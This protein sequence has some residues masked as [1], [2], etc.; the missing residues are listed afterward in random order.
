MGRK[1]DTARGISTGGAL[2]GGFFVFAFAAL[3]AFVAVLAF[4]GFAHAAAYEYSNVRIDAQ[5][6]T[7]ADFRVVEHRVL[8]FSGRST[9]YSQQ[10]SYVANNQLMVVNTVRI[11]PIDDEGNVAGEWTTM[12]PTAFKTAWRDGVS[13]D[14]LSELTGKNAY[15][16]DK[17][18]NTIHLYFPA[19]AGDSIV[20]ELD[21]SIANGA[22][23]YKDI[24][25]VCMK[26]VNESNVAD[27]HNVVFTVSLPVP[28]GAT[29]APGENVYAW[30]HGPSD[31][32]VD[33]QGAVVTFTDDL[34]RAGQYAEAHVV[35]PS[36]WL[37]NISGSSARIYKD[38]THLPWVLKA[39]AKWQDSYRYSAM[40]D[41]RFSL[42]VGAICLLIM[43][44]GL[45]L[46]HKFGKAHSLADAPVEQLSAQA[47]RDF[48][49]G[50]HPAMALRLM[51]GR[52]SDR[53]FAA[54]VLRLCD[55]GFLRFVRDAD[56]KAV[57]R[58]SFGRAEDSIDNAAMGIFESLADGEGV[59]LIDS[60]TCADSRRDSF[61]E[62]VKSWLKFT[63]SR[64]AE[65]GFADAGSARCA[66]IMRIVAGVLVFVSLFIGSATSCR[67]A[68]V[69]VLIT[70]LALFF[71]AGET[72]R[73]S[74]Q[75][76]IVIASLDAYANELA[77][78]DEL[79][80]E[81]LFD[82]YCLG[83]TWTAESADDSASS[84]NDIPAVAVSDGS[85]LGGC[86]QN[87]PFTWGC[88]I[89]AAIPGFY[90]R[91]HHPESTVFSRS[92]ARIKDVASRLRRIGK[93][94]DGAQAA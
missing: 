62:A 71:L 44:A 12:T 92:V 33:N 73:P 65:A 36:S 26:F 39:E 37:R 49:H 75:G 8:Q 45:A 41:D 60:A 56:R 48:L 72:K 74:K 43:L 90:K 24:G 27:S 52:S 88:A 82:A 66:H 15:S 64:F 23:A 77:S 34:V 58:A 76:S 86:E 35:F 87:L 69:L 9:E 7:D 94:A 31:G 63:D 16:Y 50:N 67:L 40:S 3:M 6:Q 21:Y 84:R 22:L 13:G 80:Q 32:S 70:A 20:V 28:E 57:A 93:K 18:W 25:D 5:V 30:G 55:Q 47:G 83:M 81:Q 91:T 54:T 79:S 61:F 10:F 17:S 85:A 14:T 51:H 68:S 4:P 42:V 78:L 11:A 46:G 38:D 53:E 29:A 2:A 59:V 1:L 19:N 89:E